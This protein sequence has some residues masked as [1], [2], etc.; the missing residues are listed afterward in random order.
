MVRHRP[1]RVARRAY[2]RARSGERPAPCRRSAGDR[3]PRKTG[4]GGRP[5]RPRPDQDGDRAGR[6]DGCPQ[7]APARTREQA[8]PTQARLRGRGHHLPG[9]A[10]RTAGTAAAAAALVERRRGCAAGKRAHARSGVQRF[11]RPGH[12]HPG[13][14]GPGG[15]ALRA[16]ARARYQVV[17]RHRARRRRR[18][19]DER[20][21]GACRGGARTQRDRRRGAE[22]GAGNRGA[23]RAARIHRARPGQRFA[24]PGSRQ[25]YRRHADPGRPRPH[26]AS[27]DRRHDRVGQVGRDQHDGAVAALPALSGTMPADHDRPQDARALGL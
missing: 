11:R 2:G 4:T 24:H 1:G 18:P 17:A 15:D 19:V 12:D 8:P 26:A 3:S 20:G 23:P 9:A 13:A 25:G 16:R 6:C 21:F 27:P 14:A 5:S 10:A 7:A 22:P